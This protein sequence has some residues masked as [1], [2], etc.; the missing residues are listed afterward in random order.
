MFSNAGQIAPWPAGGHRMPNQAAPGARPGGGSS[1]ARAGCPQVPRR[2]LWA[3]P[4]Q[5]RASVDGGHACETC[6]FCE[7][8][9]ICW[10]CRLFVG[11]RSVANF[12]ESRSAGSSSAPGFAGFRRTSQGYKSSAN[13]HGCWR[14]AGFA[15][16]AGVGA[17]L[18]NAAVP[19]RSASSSSRGSAITARPPPPRAASPAP[20]RRSPQQARFLE[21]CR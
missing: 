4:V 5:V 3:Q 10:P 20:R 9:C 19:I 11:L 6:E 12:C 7:G 13:P 8:P 1:S 16:F 18:G 21:A 14:F 2:S 15:A 17:G